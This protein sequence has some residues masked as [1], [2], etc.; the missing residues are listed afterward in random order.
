[1]E[2]RPACRRPTRP[3]RVLLL[4]QCDQP[5]PLWALRAA[6]ISRLSATGPTGPDAADVPSTGRLTGRE[7]AAATLAAAAAVT[8]AEAE[9]GAP[10]ASNGAGGRGHDDE[11]VSALAR[12]ASELQLMLQR[13]QLA[14]T[15]LH[16]QMTYVFELRRRFDAGVAS[17]SLRELS[18]M[19]A[20][21]CRRT[22]EAHESMRGQMGCLA[23]E[24]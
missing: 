13:W 3:H 22:L 10:A 21:E 8:Q 7:A 2:A 16:G 18:I 23:L 6:I 9:A 24:M 19:A 14:H 17:V 12:E 11:R 15:Q 1:M 5:A 20:Q 4:L